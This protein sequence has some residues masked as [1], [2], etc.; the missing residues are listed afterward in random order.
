[1]KWNPYGHVWAA[2]AVETLTITDCFNLFAKWEARQHLRYI[3]NIFTFNIWFLFPVVHKKAYLLGPENVSFGIQAS[4]C[5][6][7]SLT[8][9]YSLWIPD[10]ANS[11]CSWCHTGPHCWIGGRLLPPCL[12]HVQATCQGKEQILLSRG[13]SVAWLSL[14][15]SPAWIYRGCTFPVHGLLRWWMEMAVLWLNGTHCHGIFQ[16]LVYRHLVRCT[17]PW[18]HF[19]HIPRNSWHLAQH[20]TLHWLHSVEAKNCIDVYYDCRYEEKC[21][22]VYWLCMQS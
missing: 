16:L 3:E 15:V 14:W 7:T 19:V 4:S 1:M 8:L 11:L 6:F 18:G 13:Q 5:P 20:V 10:M 17:V 9:S 22:P 2:E 12:A 21:L